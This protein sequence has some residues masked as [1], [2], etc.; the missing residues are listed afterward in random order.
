MMELGFNFFFLITY[1][2][3][4]CLEAHNV[5]EPQYIKWEINKS[6]QE[7]KS[8]RKTKSDVSASA[9]WHPMSYLILPLVML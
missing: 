9:R 5:V 3:L 1:P 2:G 7:N 4:P 6:Q 8:S